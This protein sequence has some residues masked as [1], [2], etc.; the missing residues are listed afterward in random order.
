MLGNFLCFSA[1]RILKEVHRQQQK[2]E[3]LPSMQSVKISLN[4]STKSALEMLFC[5]ETWHMFF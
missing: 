3:K 4:C 1:E 2:H 5:S